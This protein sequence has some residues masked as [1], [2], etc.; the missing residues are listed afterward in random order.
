[1]K[2]ERFASRANEMP[3]DLGTIIS[4]FGR[5]NVQEQVLKSTNQQS[6][7][8]IFRARIDCAAGDIAGTS[9]TGPIRLL[10]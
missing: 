4:G 5:D 3:A 1:M 2:T 8:W 6:T 9:R 10:D 7:S